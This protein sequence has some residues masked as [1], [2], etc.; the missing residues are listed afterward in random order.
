MFERAE[1]LK[2]LQGRSLVAEDDGGDRVDQALVL[3]RSHEAAAQ[4]ITLFE[5]GH[6]VTL[7]AQAKRGGQSGRAGA[8]HENGRGTC[9]AEAWERR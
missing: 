4:S 9:H 8:K 7:L 3:S 5:Q 1:I 2:E 6:G